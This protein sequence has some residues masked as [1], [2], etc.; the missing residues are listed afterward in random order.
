MESRKKGAL[1]N[2]VCQVVLMGYEGAR[3]AGSQRVT[4]GEASRWVA[5]MRRG[6]VL[7]ATANI[8]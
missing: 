7:V 4:W 8:S 5:G 6:S 3:V 1:E 2:R